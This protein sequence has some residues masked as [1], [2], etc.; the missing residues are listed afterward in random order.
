MCR[1][2]TSCLTY[3]LRPSIPWL[4]SHSNPVAGNSPFEKAE[5]EL[6]PNE[7]AAEPTVSRHNSPTDPRGAGFK[8]VHLLSRTDVTSLNNRPSAMAGAR[9]RRDRTCARESQLRAPSEERKS[10]YVFVFALTFG[11]TSQRCL[12]HRTLTFDRGK[13]ER[14][15]TTQLGRVS[16]QL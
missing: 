16:I 5:F 13:R 10:G 9:R 6:K 2:E 15:N 7:V 11:A 14:G 8:L 12:L 4:E 1:S 3:R